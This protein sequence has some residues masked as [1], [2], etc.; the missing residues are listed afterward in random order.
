MQRT[1]TEADYIISLADTRNKSMR[2]AEWLVILVVLSIVCSRSRVV[3]YSDKRM[4]WGWLVFN[5]L[6]FTSPH[7]ITCLHM[8]RA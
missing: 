4:V 7:T 5:K 8:I 3:L 2:E 1:T 6:T